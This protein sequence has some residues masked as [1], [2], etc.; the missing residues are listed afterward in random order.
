MFAWLF[1]QKSDTF[2]ACF[3]SKGDQAIVTN[4]SLFNAV[5]NQMEDVVPF[6]ASIMTAKSESVHDGYQITRNIESVF[7]VQ[8][9]KKMSTIKFLVAM[10]KIHGRR[11]FEWRIV[12]ND[13]SITDLLFLPGWT[14]CEARKAGEKSVR[15]SA[16]TKVPSVGVGKVERLIDE[17]NDSL[18]K[19]KRLI[20]KLNDSSNAT[21]HVLTV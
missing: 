15:Y 9:R 19:V 21:V 10:N 7:V 16:S 12:N 8:L 14:F 2:V 13:E 5:S 4:S 11:P 18:G 6:K 20:D 17:M 1:P 3:D